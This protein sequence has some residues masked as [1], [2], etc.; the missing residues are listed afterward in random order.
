MTPLL[1]D[2]HALLWWLKGG[3]Q[4]SRHAIEAIASPETEVHVSPASL[5][6]ASIKRAK[7][8]LET[9]PD[10]ERWVRNEGFRELPIRLEHGQAAGA[11]PPFHNDPFDRLL[12]AQAKLEGLTIVT[13]DP[14]F[15]AYGVALLIA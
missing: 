15:K 13:R 1:L 10:L 5:W 9:P 12:I 8:R 6:E 11:L 2:T 3:E 4:L 14:A 7:G